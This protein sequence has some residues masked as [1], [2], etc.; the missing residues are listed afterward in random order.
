MKKIIK[1]LSIFIVL[2]FFVYIPVSANNNKKEITIYFFHGDGCPHCAEE[3]KYLETIKDKYSNINIVYYEVWYNEDNASF[4][5]ELKEELDI[6]GNGVPFTI[7]GSTPTTGFSEVTKDRL[8]RIINYYLE[9]DYVDVVDQVKNGTYVDKV[10]DKFQEEEN[11]TDKDTIISVPLIGKVNLKDFSIPSAAMLVGFVD[12]FN[13]CAMW[14]LLFLISMLLTMKDRKRMWTLGLSFLFTSGFVYMLIMLFW[15]KVSINI[16]TSI[17][18]RNIIAVFAI[19]AAVFN[20]RKFFISKDS[21]CTVTNDKKRRNILEKIKKFTHE[22]NFL[23]AICGVV[24]LAISV[25]IVELACSLGLPL[26]FTQLLAINNV[27]GF[28]AFIYTLIYILFFLIDDIIV[29]VIAMKTMKVTAISTKYNKYS[30]LIG[31]II[32]LIIG[33]LLLI[34]PEWLMFNF[35]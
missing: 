13:P 16:T 15:Y 34:K 35:K 7:I 29:F 33:V 8:N 3:E 2:T 23:L 28:M 31:G 18:I 10:E 27:D 32:M 4:M 6:D 20:I 17:F 14:V 5:T 11:K 1:Y 24:G 26:I 22:K 12:G 30:H 9:N 21:G 25:N 19:V